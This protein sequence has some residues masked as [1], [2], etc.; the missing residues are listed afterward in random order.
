MA[1]TLHWSDY[2]VFALSLFAYAL[3]GLYFRWSA[4]INNLFK[5]C[6][7][8]P[9][10]EVKPQTTQ[11]IFLAN[12]QLGVLPIMASITAS[13][14]SGA[15]LLG[16]HLEVYLYG[17]PLA[18]NLLVQLV[19]HPMVSELYM[20]VLYKLHLVSI[21]QYFE[22]RFGLV[23]KIMATIT[24]IIQMLF[25][26]GASLFAPAVALSAMTGANL[27]LTILGTGALTT[28]YTAMGGLKGV[29]WTDVIQ[30]I[31][32]LI[33]MIVILAVGLVTVGG[34]VTMWQTAWMD[35]K[36]DQV[37][38]SVDP[39]I[40]YTFWSLTIGS[41]GT[42]LPTQASNQAQIQRY[43]SCKSL[44]TAKIAILLSIP[45]NIVFI[46]LHVTIGLVSY[47][48][49]RGCDP[50]MSGQLP[51]YDMLFPFLTLKLFNNIPVLRGLVLSVI[52]AA[53]FSTISSG[54]NSL[55]A[56]GIQDVFLPIYKQKKPE[57][58]IKV[59]KLT[60]FS[61]L[62]AV[63]LGFVT[64]GIAVILIYASPNILRIILSVF[65]ATGG[66]IFLLHTIGIFFPFINNWGACAGFAV[67]VVGTFWVSIGGIFRNRIND[68]PGRP[69]SI[70]SCPS[71]ITQVPN[72]TTPASSPH[73]N[74]EEMGFSFYDLS[75]LWL[76]AF[77]ML[78]GFV[79]ASIV[80]LLSG[81]NTKKP[82]QQSL[83][84]SQAI[85][86]YNCFPNCHPVQSYD[87]TASQADVEDDLQ[88]SGR[89]NGVEKQNGLYKNSS[90]II[91]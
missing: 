16:N 62:V 33:G 26:V 6:L 76:T 47:V 35:G 81:M 75:Y 38:F 72:G 83:L 20:P 49:F 67:S 88:S 66:P 43:L 50:K 4:Q 40:R 69:P 78:I 48:Y 10:K 86:F 14:L 90:V 56:V 1:V 68:L 42:Y 54:L 63:F 80:S 87:D 12:R 21:N 41:L 73:M 34:P 17:L 31:I 74:L 15:T 27:L 57:K 55:S 29:V 77:A 36:I 30:L 32:M 84:A 25:Y 70:D 52:F 59:K 65:G 53:A 24:F 7:G 11:E 3:V 23:A 64:T 79:V 39:F 58:E 9:M 85:T 18:C 61:R 37:S 19:L 28:F 44:K 22:M 8:R 89:N 5:R 46:F 91:F 2:F 71:A 51:R 45:V 82:I 60:L 13:F